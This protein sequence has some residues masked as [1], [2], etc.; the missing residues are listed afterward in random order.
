MEQFA[1]L[2]NTAIIYRRGVAFIVILYKTLPV[3][4]YSCDRAVR[5]RATQLDGP[6]ILNKLAGL[7]EVFLEELSNS[8]NIYK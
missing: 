4:T 3:S 5:Y 2:A 8:L 6:S 7:E 1:S